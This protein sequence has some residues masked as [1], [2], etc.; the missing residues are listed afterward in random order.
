MGAALEYIVAQVM[1]PTAVWGAAAGV[2]TPAAGDSL[3]VRDAPQGAHLLN[4]WYY[5]NDPAALIG[6]RVSMTSA[7]LHDQTLGLNQP[8]TG[9]L[10]TG[11][12]VFFTPGNSQPLF[13]QDVLLIRAT[14]SAVA[15]EVSSCGMLI[16]YPELKGSNTRLIDEHEMHSRKVNQ[17]NVAV[18]L[19]PGAQAGLGG[20]RGAIAI[21]AGIDLFKP[22]TDYALVG[23]SSNVILAD[24]LLG[25]SIR[26]SDTGNLRLGIPVNAI[27]TT[28][29]RDWFLSLTRWFRMPLIPVINSS[30]RAGTFVE[31]V[32]G[33]AAITAGTTFTFHFVQLS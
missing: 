3:Q 7:K 10:V 30:S 13:G 5:N 32:C 22:N 33:E 23:C 12:Q 19:A 9:G 14:G 28:L 4:W 8:L 18:A 24:H 29:S 6:A 1:A 15:T 21:N 27:D 17:F 2:L 16:Y 20:H 31:L 25:V 26:G 11:T